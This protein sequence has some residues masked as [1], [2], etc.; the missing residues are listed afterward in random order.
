MN[1]FLELFCAAETRTRILI[2]LALL[3]AYR[4]AFHLPVPGVDFERLEQLR[5]TGA[6]GD[7]FAFGLM[8]A[9]SGG[10]FGSCRL[11]TLGVLPWLCASLVVGLLVRIVPRLSVLANEG[12]RGR[13]AVRRWTRWGTV[14][15]GIVQAIVLVVVPLGRFA[16]GE[17][18][19][20]AL[21]DSVFYQA[22][23]VLT[24][25][26]GSL[27]LM[28]IAGQIDERGVGHGILLIVV[29]GLLA[30]L[31][32][33]LA[34]LKLTVGDETEWLQSVV[35]LGVLFLGIVLV[36]RLVGRFGGGRVLR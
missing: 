5:A 18:V 22:F 23:V 24:L 4:V 7:A 15:M 27:I 16:G 10:S 30:R 13:A 31:P 12:E 20:P 1:A 28:W 35:T 11:L 29:A 2:T 21:A 33:M 8:N 3:A 32:T 25:T 17:V 9:F 19:D 36:V 14:A 34:Q 6:S 26:T